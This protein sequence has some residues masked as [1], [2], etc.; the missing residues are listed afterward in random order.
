MDAQNIIL[1]CRDLSV[2]YTIRNQQ[3][4]VQSHL[5]MVLKRGELTCLLGANGM[6][7][8]TLLRT[9]AGVQ[10]PLGGE[11]WVNGKLLSGYS[12]RERSRQIG[13]VLTD[14]TMAG[15]L[16]VY[17]LVA[18]GR[19]PYT[20]FLGHLSREDDAVI[21]KSLEAVGMMHKAGSYVAELSDGERQKAMIAKA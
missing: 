14:R 18:L 20:N 15:G 10:S 1:E 17:D 6:G 19:Q 9:L 21:R 7:K 13:I 16:S 2:G 3:R 12:E 5:N 11:L 8:S 4:V